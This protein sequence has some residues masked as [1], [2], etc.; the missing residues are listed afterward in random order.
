MIWLVQAVGVLGIVSHVASFQQSRRS[1]VLLL[2]MLGCV[3]WT[4]HFGLLGFYTAAAANLV[5]AVRSYVFYAYKRRENNWVLYG[6]IAAIAAVAVL[7]WQGPMS[8]LPFVASLFSTYGGWSASAQRI[9]W[10]TLPAPL[11]WLAH[12]V[13]ARSV[14]VVS[15][16][17][18]LMSI[19]VGL[20]RHRGTL[21]RTDTV[22]KSS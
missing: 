11:F 18:V 9:R 19:V 16:V 1:R 14:G 7:T 6:F 8:L 5:A 13:L 17:V 20:Y 22:Q 3:F 2:L 12:N 15:D 21:E 10:L 4:V